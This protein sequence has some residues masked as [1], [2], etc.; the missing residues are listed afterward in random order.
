M[1]MIALAWGKK[2][3]QA[4]G[5]PT[6]GRRLEIGRVRQARPLPIAAGAATEMVA[7]SSLRDDRAGPGRSTCRG[8]GRGADIV[9]DS[10]S[11]QLTC[12]HQLTCV[13][14]Q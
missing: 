8:P 2:A 14:L 5:L 12:V 7:A 6:R 1:V 13:R 11:C 4:S 3:W 9:S 10:L